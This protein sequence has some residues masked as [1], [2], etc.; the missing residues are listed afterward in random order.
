M[1]LELDNAAGEAVKTENPILTTSSLPACSAC[2]YTTHI[3]ACQ[4]NST[5]CIIFTNSVSYHNELSDI[6]TIL[7]FIL[8]WKNFS[9]LHTNTT[10]Y[11]LWLHGYL[12]TRAL[13]AM[14]LLT[15][16]PDKQLVS[17]YIQKYQKL[18]Q[19]FASFSGRQHARDGLIRGLPRFI[20]S[21]TPSSQILLFDPPTVF[22]FLAT[23][24]GILEPGPSWPLLT[25]LHSL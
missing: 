22:P 1:G 17:C 9:S 6:A 15:Q 14:N 23:Y 25:H 3:A 20:I 10:N 8:P 19:I 4:P 11:R 13:L 12:V 18:S 2:C 21:F 24:K 7:N 16:Q 5:S